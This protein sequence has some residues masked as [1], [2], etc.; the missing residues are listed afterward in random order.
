MGRPTKNENEKRKKL[1]V[2]IDA[3]VYDDLNKYVDD[4]MIIKSRL[5]EKIIKD[6]LKSEDE[7]K[8]D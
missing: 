3:K 2:T 1:S 6:F 4:C 7:K 5:I 8:R